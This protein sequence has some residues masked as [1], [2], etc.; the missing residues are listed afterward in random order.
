MTRLSEQPARKMAAVL[1]PGERLLAAAQYE[2]AAQRNWRSGVFA[3]FAEALGLPPDDD[4]AHARKEYG[5]LAVT[6]RRLILADSPFFGSVRRRHV[7][8]EEPAGDCRLTWYDASGSFKLQARLMM[9][10]LPGGRFASVMVRTAWPGIFGRGQ[11]EALLG[12]VN[13]VVLAF[14]DRATE[15]QEPHSGG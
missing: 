3:R 1:A 12:V 5:Y 10:H 9:F 7:Y 4:L 15:I 11:H 8:V 2:H 14:A 6:D 13:G